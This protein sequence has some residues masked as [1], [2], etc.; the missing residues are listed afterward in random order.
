MSAAESGSTVTLAAFVAS[1]RFED[2]PPAVVDRTKDLLTDAAA[3][4]VGAVD[5]EL[6]RVVIET[7]ARLGSGGARILGTARRMA[8]S[9][10]AFVNASLIN[11]LD[12]DDTDAS[13]HPGSSVI[14]AAL[15]AAELAGQVNGSELICAIVAGVQVAGRV[16]RYLKP[17]WERYREVH[18]SGSAQTL[19]AAAAAGRIMRLTP[20]RMADAFGIAAALAPVPHAGKFGWEQRRL[21]WIKDNVARAADGGLRA[22]LLAAAGFAGN[23]TVLDGARGF[24]IM[25]SSDRRDERSLRENLAT[26]DILDLSFKPYPCC[27]WIH[28][29]LDALVEARAKHRFAAG[30]VESVEVET[31][32]GV[33]NAFG[34]SAPATMVDAQFSVPYAVAALLHNV[35]FSRWH[36]A[37]HRDDGMVRA[38]ARVVRL[39]QDPQAQREYLADGRLSWKILSH[40]TIR[41]RGADPIRAAENIALGSSQRPL[42]R[43]ELRKKA[44][45]LMV[46]ALGERG[47]QALIEGVWRA[48]AMSDVRELFDLTVGHK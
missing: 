40:V 16:A 10:A 3:C 5:S 2:L 19:G 37:A 47:A 22:A 28:T 15:A 25:A 41:V 8:S 45:D 31:I 30:D 38:T 11:A 21:G 26:L 35:P 27:R 29:T 42:R 17:S 13:G 24:W 14:A 46:E 9:E 20:D 23:R 34:S 44:G 43:D 12:Y 4:A 1:L 36:L 6:G 33:V 7:G 48:E 39:R 18:G 32:D